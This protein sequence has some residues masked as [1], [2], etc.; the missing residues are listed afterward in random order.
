MIY[1]RKAQS[2]DIPRILEILEDGRTLLK[3]DGSPQWQNG[4]PG[5]AEI[6]RDIQRQ[7]CYVLMVEQAIAGVTTIL[8]EPDENYQKIYDGSWCK[9]ELY[10]TFHRVALAKNYRGQHL[11]EYLFSNLLTVVALKGFKNVRID[12][13]R[14]NQRMQ[15]IVLKQGFEYR[16]IIMILSDQNDPERLAYELNL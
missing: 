3:D 1:L 12:T 6:Q 5:L 8:T 2:E 10:C 9:E 13:H 4:D 14:M 15:K 16:G 7:E 11:S